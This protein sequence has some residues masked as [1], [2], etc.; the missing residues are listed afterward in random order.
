M[1]YSVVVKME[2]FKRGRITYIFL[3]SITI[4][5]GGT[6]AQDAADNKDTIVN[7]EDEPLCDKDK[8]ETSD[9]GCGGG[10][11]NRKTTTD[12]TETS[13]INKESNVKSATSKYTSAANVESKYTRTNNM[14]F[15]DGG[16]FQMGTNSPLIMADGEGPE[17]ETRVNDFYLDVHEV[18]N[19]EFEL[20]VDATNHVTE[21][22]TFGDSFV[23]EGIISEEIKK[24]ITQAVAA[25]PWW[26]PVKKADWR[27]P[28]GPDTSLEGRMTH[29]VLHVSWNDAVAYCK[30]AGKRL[31][32]E[33]EWE[34]ACKGGLKNR[35]FPWG[36][37]DV[38][39][40]TH[41]MN[42]WQGD[43]PNTNTAEDGYEKTCPVDEFEPQNKYGL[44][45]MVGN[46]WEW[47]SDF[48]T[49]DHSNSAQDNPK[50]PETGTDKVKKGGSYMCH[51]SY[52]YRYRC[53]ARSQN[54]P[55]SSSSNLGFR[56]AADKL[57]EYLQH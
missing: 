33:A 53:S 39:K 40:N 44:K 57:P 42:I 6:W 7:N 1:Y 9:C 22:E 3:I 52:C 50:G 38:P 47:T 48:W 30:W 28:E 41:K 17:R 5:N 8:T 20:F 46:A 32:T 21:T 49:P 16:T 10:A 23:F 12:D 31:P 2:L 55:D 51:E 26:L 19:A 29:P 45:N 18:S 36:N 13:T 14:V 24:D 56:C 54:T 35:L 25:A 11:T 37:K 27:H 34:Y 43:F 15:I 4:L